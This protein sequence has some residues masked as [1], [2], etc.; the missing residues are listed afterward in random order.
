MDTFWQQ[1][2]GWAGI[3]ADPVRERACVV[4][5]PQIESTH[6]GW[7]TI[8]GVKYTHD[9]IIRS[10]GR[11]EKRKKKLSRKLFGTSHFVSED[12]ARDLFEEGVQRV[13]VGS[14]Q[15]GVLKLSDEARKIFRE[16][17]LD[18]LPTPKAVHVWNETSGP[19]VA[20]FHITC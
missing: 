18:L 9:V 10:D 2:N 1:L 17:S 3:S 15:Y 8:D 14:G 4:K 12:E 16:C 20:L 11:V 13:I 5:N 6:F 19:A 7:I